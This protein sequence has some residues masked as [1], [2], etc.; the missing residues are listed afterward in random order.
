M[1]EIFNKKI[2]IIA[3]IIVVVFELI[4]EL[5][6]TKTGYQFNNNPLV[7]R[8]MAAPIKAFGICII[9]WVF[10]KKKEKK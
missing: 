2:F 1:N 6:Q 3:T 4:T 7:N 9:F 8:L 10:S 5:W